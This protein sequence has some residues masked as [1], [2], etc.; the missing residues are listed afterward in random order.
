MTNAKKR[1]AAFRTVLIATLMLISACETGGSSGDEASNNQVVIAGIETGNASLLISQ[2]ELVWAPCQVSRDIE[3]ATLVVPLDYVNP[4]AQ[5]IDIA[6][7]RIPRA[8]SAT[9]SRTL[10]LNPGGPGGSGVNYLAALSFRGQLSEA[11]RA[12]F[13][14]VSFDPRGVGLSTPV[15]CDTQALISRD[16]YAVNR[17][18]IAANVASYSE[19]AAQCVE[20]EQ[21]YVQQLGSHNV[22]QDMNEMRKALGVAQLDFVGFSYGT[23]LGGLYMQTYPDTTGRFILDGSMSPSP[24]L[25]T[26]VHGSLLP[27]QANIDNLV[28]ACLGFPIVCNP[29]EFATALQQRVDELGAQ[30]PTAESNLL[31]GIVQLASSQ[32]GFEQVLIGRLAAYISSGDVAELEF[33]DRLLGISEAA[34]DTSAVNETVNIAVM[35]ADDATRPTID[36]LEALSEIYNED[37]DLLA[38]IHLRVAGYCAGWPQAINPIPNIATN[39]A[40]PSLVI[41]GPTDAQ[42]ALVFSEQMAEAVGGQFLRSE[43]SGHTTVFSGKNACTDTVAETFLLTGELPEFSVCAAG[44][45]SLASDWHDEFHRP[46]N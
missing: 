16:T 46:L 9:R 30:V 38:E 13:D 31:F 11:L 8:E 29:N 12:E 44:A 45:Q 18:Q 4:D 39:Q 36:S 21:G 15:N 19:F 32:P 33:L 23:R 34:E 2:P 37:S 43:H 41:G 27:G 7:A 5:T 20:E 28:A 3:C 26:L 10:L 14:F 40:P 25:S 42:T 1:D 17:E 35:C 6:L 22:V 24:E